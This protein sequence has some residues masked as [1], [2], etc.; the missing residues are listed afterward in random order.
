MS[1][2]LI[3]GGFFVFAALMIMKVL[4]TIL[5]LPLMAAWIALVVQMPLVAYLNNILLAGS[6]NLGSAMAVVIFG[7]MFA[8]V[9]MKTGVSDTIIKKAAELAGDK[10]RSIAIILSFATIFV[11]LGMSG[12]GA[13]IMVGS[14]VLPI[15]MSAGISP[16]LA[17]SILLLALQTGLLGNAA[18]YGTFIGIF[19]GEIT[20]SYYAPAFTISLLGTVACIL[21]NIKNT[22]EKGESSTSFVQVIGIVLKGILLLPKNLCVSLYEQIT[23]ATTAKV[24]SLVVKK[25]TVP[26]AALVAPI[27]PLVT[28]YA[29]KAVVGFGKATQGHVDPV[30]ASVLGF[31]L[32]SVYAIMLTK[33][34]QLINVMAGSIT[35]GIKDVAGVIFLFM[36]IGMLVAAVMDPTVAKVLNPLLLAILPTHRWTVFAFFALLAPTALY[37]GPLN[38]FGMGVGIAALIGTLNILPAPIVVGTFLAVGYIQGASDPTNSQNTWISGFINVDTSEILKKTLPYTWAMCLLLL[39]YV[40]LMRW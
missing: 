19:G 36:G 34:S 23:K 17:S 28:V 37:R 10:P 16:L 25:T 32:A 24:S 12:L 30:A 4:P 35:E 9:I 14:I 38:M 20:M 11:F 21:I 33:P 26:A 22:S 3:L 13:V 18:S 2:I 6:M 15:M 7:A 27:I 5:A 29:F 40:T 31:F 1:G 8:K 39:L